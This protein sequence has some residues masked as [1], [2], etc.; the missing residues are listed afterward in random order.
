MGDCSVTADSRIP[1][2]GEV[3]CLQR[4]GPG[5]GGQGRTGPTRGSRRRTVAVSG[6]D[7]GLVKCS[8]C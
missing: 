8:L 5:L 2:A 6:G 4:V 7:S 3:V 1:G